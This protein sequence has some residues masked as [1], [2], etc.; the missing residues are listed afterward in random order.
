MGREINIPHAS[1]I[2]VGHTGFEPV[3]SGS[4]DQR[5]IQTELMPRISRSTAHA[6]CDGHAY[7]VSCVCGSQFYAASVFFHKAK[8]TPPLGATE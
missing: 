3:T 1:F 2:M 4:G 7:G 8:D 5:S 6:F